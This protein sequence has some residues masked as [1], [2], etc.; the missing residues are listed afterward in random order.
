MM[1]W[2]GFILVTLALLGHACF[3]VYGAWQ[4]Q[5]GIFKPLV[6]ALASFALIIFLLVA[7]FVGCRIIEGTTNHLI[8]CSMSFFGIFFFL[9]IILILGYEG[10]ED[11]GYEH[12]QG[13]A[14]IETRP[15][16]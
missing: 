14:G 12:A 8:S 2:L 16:R 6:A 9:T 5:G 15:R 3:Y 7:I 10:N 11:A 13:D 1:E 4:Y